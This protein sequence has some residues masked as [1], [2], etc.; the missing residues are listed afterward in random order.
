MYRV[1]SC[2]LYSVIENYACIDYLCCQY[3]T[4]S[5]ISSDKISEQASYNILLGIGIPE[6]LMNLVSCHGFVEKPN[7]TSILNL[8]SR[9]VDYYLAKIIVIIQHNSNKLSSVPNDVKL[10]IH[11]IDK[12]KTYF[13]MACIIAIYSVA[14]TIN[15]FHIQY[16]LHFFTNKTS[17]IINKRKWMKC[18]INT[19]FHY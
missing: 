15:K 8:R 4:L 11:V 14:N 3:K 7:L 12:Q 10:R 6:V 13:V 5:S 16:Y 18:F 9:L 19:I 2:V 17:I 1:L